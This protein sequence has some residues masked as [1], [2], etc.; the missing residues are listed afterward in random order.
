MGWSAVTLTALGALA[1]SLAWYFSV[2]LN[3]AKDEADAIFRAES[4]TKIASAGV[5]IAEAEEHSR[6]LELELAKTNE[7][8]AQAEE[9]AADAK[10]ALE[11]FKAPRNLSDNQIETLAR[12]MSSFKGH[13]VSIGAV[14]ATFETVSLADQI[15]RAL[16]MAGVNA[17]ANAGAAQVQVGI[18]RGVV[19]KAT[20]GNVKGEM[21]AT[22]FAKALKDKNIAALATGGLHESVLLTME[23]TQQGVDRNADGRE[24]VVIVVGDK[25]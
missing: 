24:W 12:E 10:L 15:L 22:A 5:R 4:S 11:Q 14:P 21:F 6:V 16:T 8:T 19:A 17:N 3:T 13:R 18:V 20:T 1:G 7:R 9:R 23:K 25:P 2:Q